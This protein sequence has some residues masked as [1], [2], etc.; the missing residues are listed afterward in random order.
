MATGLGIKEALNV[1]FV[2]N[3]SA[4]GEKFEQNQFF[5]FCTS[6][7]TL[8]MNVSLRRNLISIRK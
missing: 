5:I 6:E 1:R 4:N 7:A 2:Q 3:S 8:N